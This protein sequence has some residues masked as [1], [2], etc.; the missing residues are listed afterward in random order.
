MT[1][2]PASAAAAA[3][4]VLL[5]AGCGGSPGPALPPDVVPVGVG[6]GA[7]YRPPPLSRDVR[8]ARPVGRMRCSRA[9]AKR[10]GA[11]VE[12]IVNRHVVLLPAGVG[13]A[14]P[15]HRR[16]AYVFSGRCSYPVRTLEPTGVVEIAAVKGGPPTLGELFSLWGQ[17]LGPARLAAFKGPVATWV[18][19]RPHRSDPRSVVL[20]RHAVIVLEVGP[21]IP[22]HASYSFPPGL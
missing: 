18:N 20:S 1:K 5:I 14:P 15:Y 4:I 2:M 13:V 6:S 8:R 9:S 3:W 10:A 19:G 11:H 21:R 17:P 7:A 22:P 12:L 16:G